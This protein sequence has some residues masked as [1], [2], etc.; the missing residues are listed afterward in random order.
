VSVERPPEPPPYRHPLAPLP[1]DGLSSAPA[2][3]EAT[4]SPTDA[5]AAPGGRVPPRLAK[6]AS[7]HPLVIAAVIVSVTVTLATAVL[8]VV[9]FAARLWWVFDILTSYRPQFVLVL[10]VGVLALAA[11]RCWKI[12]AVAVLALLLNVGQVAPVYIDHQAAARPGSPTLSIAHL[13]LQ[14][15]VGDLAAMDQWLATHPADIVVFLHTTAPTAIHLQGG[16]LGYRMAYPRVVDPAA[17]FR[18]RFDPASPEVIVMTDRADVTAFTPTQPGLPTAVVQIQARLGSTS[19]TLLGLHTLSPGTSVRQSVRDSELS[20]VGRWLKD[21]PKPAV[22]FGDFNTTYYSP[23]LADLLHH[24]GATSSQ[25]GFGIQATWPRQFR[26][27]GIA[28]DQSVY[29]GAIT[30]IHRQRGPNLGSE[31]RA[32]VVTYALAN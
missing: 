17:P 30:V 28:I 10:G 8:T 7:R 23:E 26:P 22:A 5:A 15:R 27:A 12:L 6:L 31:H 24:A 29:T 4:S 16:E 11:L 2:R 20:A 9:A 21:A 18:K 32:L 19:L 13:N 1:T 14:S 3:P 25:L